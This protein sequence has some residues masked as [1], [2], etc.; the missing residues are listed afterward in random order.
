M[1]K[2]VLAGIRAT[3]RLHLGNYLGAIKGMLIL[4]ESNEY[5][6][7][8]MVAD[9]HTLTTPFDVAQLR[10][11]RR[12]VIID[13][14][15]A[16][17]NP[18]KSI[19]FLQSDIPEHFELAFYFSS[20]MSIARM[21]HLPTYKEKIKQYPNDNTMSL[22]NYPILMASDILIYKAGLVPVGIDQEP[23]LEVA[24]EIA[25]KMNQ[26][27]HTDFPEPIRFITKGEYIPSLTGEG[28]MSKSVEGSYINLTDTIDVVRK[29]IRSVATATKVGGQ[30]TK[31]V[32]TLFTLTDFYLPEEKNR[33]KQAY[34]NGTLQFVELKDAITEAIYKE[35]APIQ[36]KRYDIEKDTTYINSVIVQ[37]AEKAHAIARQTMKEVK[38][39]IG[40]L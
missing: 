39:K 22:L 27:Y 37:G 18:E 21:Q 15:S 9:A 29:K 6:T 7:I 19:I 5:E 32:Q 11:N 14:L 12:E 34:D 24:R 30:M 33:F 36:E 13:Y 40:L 2:R 31:G 23:H 20:L 25:R 16:G 3:G 1:K 8:Y 35:L 38:E 26:K 28:K 4:Q 17:L 10:K